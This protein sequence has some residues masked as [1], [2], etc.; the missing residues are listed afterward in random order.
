MGYFSDQVSH[1]NEK[2]A[3]IAGYLAQLGEQA[4]ARI[5]STANA[6]S[7]MKTN[8]ELIVPLGRFFEFISNFR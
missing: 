5:I 3:K 7:G 8:K 2:R 6:D 1:P 4:D